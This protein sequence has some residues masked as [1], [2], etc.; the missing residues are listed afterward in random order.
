M[1]DFAQRALDTAV[2][3]GATY[4][5]VRVVDQ[6][7]RYLATKNGQAS[8]VR[9]SESLGIGVRVIAAG[10]WGFASS[11]D[12]SLES[13][14]RTAARAVEIATASA[15]AKRHDVQLAPEAAVVDRWQSACAVDPFAV[16]V[17]DALDLLLRVDAELRRVRGVTLA[18][19]S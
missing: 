12:L 16:S 8:G 18:E 4:A 3:R 14:D 11:D 6:H 15:L 10:A 19:G 17:S 7:Q 9:D 1:K 13:V 2:A 5:D